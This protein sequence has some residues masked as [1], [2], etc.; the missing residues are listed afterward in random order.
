MASEYFS[1]VDYLN[2]YYFP[3]IITGKNKVSFRF[4][5]NLEEA[6]C[7]VETQFAVA[8]CPSDKHIPGLLL[9]SA[10]KTFC[11]SQSGDRSFLLDAQEVEA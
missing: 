1:R 3:L 5:L 11:H 7:A 2:I 6:D 4:C 10:E 8:S 9:L